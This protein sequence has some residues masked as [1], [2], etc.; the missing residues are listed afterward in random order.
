MPLKWTISHANRTVEAVASGH[1]S[2]QDIERYLDDI[3]VSDALP[4][5]KLFDASQ[6][7][8]APADEEMMLLGARL[9]AYARLGPLGPIAFVAPPAVALQQKIHLFATLA[10]ADRPLRIFKVVKAARKWLETAV[11]NAPA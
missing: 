5:H 2:L 1:L 11:G 10:P 9:S 4:Y 8:S 3:M 7:S 6:A